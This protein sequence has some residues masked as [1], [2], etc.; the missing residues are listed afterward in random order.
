VLASLILAAV[1]TGQTPTDRN[2]VGPPD[3]RRMVETDR[4]IVQPRGADLVARRRAKRVAAAR[5]DERAY[6]ARM[7]AQARAYQA[8]QARAERMLPYQLEAQR[9]AILRQGDIERNAIMA[10]NAASLERISG[11]RTPYNSTL[12]NLGPQVAPHLQGSPLSP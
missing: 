6:Q 11:F 10:R 1:M 9:L 7:V 3:L 5:A 8:E 2:F 12:S 4:P